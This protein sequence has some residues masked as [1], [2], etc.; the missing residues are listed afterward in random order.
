MDCSI[1]AKKDIIEKYFLKINQFY[2]EYMKCNETDLDDIEE[3]YITD[4]KLKIYGHCCANEFGEECCEERDVNESIEFFKH[5]SSFE[6][7]K[8]TQWKTFRRIF[9]TIKPLEHTTIYNKFIPF[10]SNDKHN[11]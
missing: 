2:E 7:F 3:E 9:F 4:E 1:A 6:I 11:I 10:N 5:V 8:Y